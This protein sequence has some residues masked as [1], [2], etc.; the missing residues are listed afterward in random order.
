MLVY[1]RTRQ[2]SYVLMDV[3]EIRRFKLKRL[4]SEFRTK[5]D[6]AEALGLEYQVLYQLTTDTKRTSGKPFNMGDELARKVEKRLK[7][8]RGWMDSLSEEMTHIDAQTMLD[9]ASLKSLDESDQTT[10]RAI[11]QSLLSKKSPH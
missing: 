4:V 8:P 7:K 6:A 2:G 11:I 9:A 5:K 1:R 10:V 3:K